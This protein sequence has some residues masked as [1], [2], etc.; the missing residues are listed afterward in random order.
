MNLKQSIEEL[1]TKQQNLDCEVDDLIVD[2]LAYTNDRN[3]PLLDRWNFW[4]EAPKMMKKH[5][6]YTPEIFTL[7]LQEFIASQQ[8][9]RIDIGGYLMFEELFDYVADNSEFFPDALNLTAER[10]TSFLEEI[11]HHNVASVKQEKVFN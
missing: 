7:E 8:S 2:F 5:L 10:L 9:P 4:R 3:V 11:L 6:D 1:Q